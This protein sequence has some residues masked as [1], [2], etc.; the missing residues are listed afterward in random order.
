MTY[1][2]VRHAYA[3]WAPDEDRPLSS[4]GQKDAQRV[5]EILTTYPIT[6]IYSSPY[7]RAYQTI[8]PLSERLNIPIIIAPDLR[9]R[10]LCEGEIDHFSEA[11]EATWRD[12]NFAHPGGE[13]NLAAQRRS[14]SFIEKI[15]R[16]N[17]NEHVVLATHG[18]LFALLLQHFDPSIGFAFWKSL[19]MPDIFML[20]VGTNQK[21]QIQRLWGEEVNP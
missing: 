13:S 3:D 11:V 21:V 14:I 19:T 18:N 16:Q 1:Y 5:A 4:I 9:E 2:L 12:P 20:E 6:R 7:N 15:Q 8:V 10:K 17:Q